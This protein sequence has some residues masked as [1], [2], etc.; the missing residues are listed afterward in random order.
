MP[1]AIMSMGILFNLLNG[2]MQG[3]WIF[4]LAPATMYQSD[5]FTSPYFIIG[6]LLFFT[7]MLVNWS[8]DYIIRHLRK[9]GRHTALSATERH[10]PLC[11][12]R[13]LFR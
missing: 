12:F 5:W 6:T 4:Y 7:G 3:E 9:S 8:S 11:D 10:V 13:Q 1:L 2:Y